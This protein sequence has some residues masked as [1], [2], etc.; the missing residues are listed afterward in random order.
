MAPSSPLPARESGNMYEAR[1]DAELLPRGLVHEVVEYLVA[2]EGACG[3]RYL[4][5]MPPVRTF[6]RASLGFVPQLYATLV[7]SATFL[8][9][10]SRLS[11][12]PP[13][14]LGR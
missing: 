10:L 1:G 9:T 3:V 6:S 11:H 13:P 14:C 5:G 7:A 4:G 12:E 8:A 2:T